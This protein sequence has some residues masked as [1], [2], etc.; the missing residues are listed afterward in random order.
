MVSVFYGPVG[1]SPN[2]HKI[3][4]ASP[5]CLYSLTS[6]SWWRP[7]EM[8]TLPSPHAYSCVAARGPVSELATMSNISRPVGCLDPNRP[9]AVPL[10]AA[11]LVQLV[12]LG[13]AV[14]TIAATELLGMGAGSWLGFQY[15]IVDDSW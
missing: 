12:R 11:L 1:T 14:A 15:A 4:R 10:G 6:I 3:V 13:S 9:P 5:D 8:L 2:W 7:H